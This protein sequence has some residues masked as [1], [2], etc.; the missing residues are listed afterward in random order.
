MQILGGWPL[1]KVRCALTE[2]NHWELITFCVYCT[3]MWWVEGVTARFRT[4]S[5]RFRE[6]AFASTI[7]PENAPKEGNA[8]TRMARTYR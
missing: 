6:R 4:T 5:L 7:E 1:P 8:S 2:G 3:R